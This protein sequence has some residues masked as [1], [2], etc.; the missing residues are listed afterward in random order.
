MGFVVHVFLPVILGGYL[1]IRISPVFYFTHYRLDNQRLLMNTLVAALVFF[2]LSVVIN[3]FIYNGLSNVI[4]DNYD[5]VNGLEYAVIG[6]ALSIFTLA[7]SYLFKFSDKFM[8]WRFFSSVYRDNDGM[9]IIFADAFKKQIFVSVTL[10]NRKVYIGSVISSFGSPSFDTKTVRIFPYFSG[11]RSTETHELRI[12]T[13]YDNYY[14]EVA[15]NADSYSITDKEF[16]IALPV[17][18]IQSVNFFDPNL[19]QKMLEVKNE[20]S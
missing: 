6:F 15:T 10:K 17:S 14:N 5:D 7:I 3:D 13:Y 12:T 1:F 9:E 16:E 4:T 18:E 20:M 2:L 8:A 19:Y 11:F